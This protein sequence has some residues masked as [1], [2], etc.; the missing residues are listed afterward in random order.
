V[1]LFGTSPSRNVF[2]NWCFLFFRSKYQREWRTAKSSLRSRHCPLKEDRTQSFGQEKFPELMVQLL[3]RKFDKK[4]PNTSFLNVKLSFEKCCC[5]M[6]K[7]IFLF[8]FFI[9]KTVDLWIK[10][11]FFLNYFAPLEKI[12]SEFHGFR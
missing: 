7:F 10:F 12:Y 6:P 4:N 9:Q 1:T 5:K 2:L 11:L 3:S 8:G